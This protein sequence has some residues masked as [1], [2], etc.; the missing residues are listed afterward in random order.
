MVY[1]YLFYSIMTTLWLL[2]IAFSIV[3]HTLAIFTLLIEN[4]VKI[5]LSIIKIKFF[6]DIIETF[7]ITRGSG[8]NINE[9][10]KAYVFRFCVTLF[11]L[12]SVPIMAYINWLTTMN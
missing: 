7:L 8:I 6:R 10:K 1:L 4:E 3:F 11:S 9:M 2:I 5:D 12:L